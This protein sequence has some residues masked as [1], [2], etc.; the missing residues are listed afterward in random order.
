MSSELN[1]NKFVMNYS[2]WTHKEG[3]QYWGLLQT[4]FKLNV[5]DYLLP[6]NENVRIVRGL[7]AV[8]LVGLLTADF[9]ILYEKSSFELR[10]IVT[11]FKKSFS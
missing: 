8:L 4:V 5:Y 7:V 11:N 2:L 6:L 3:N 9:A 10:L 1:N